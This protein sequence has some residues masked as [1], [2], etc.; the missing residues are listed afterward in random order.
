[1]N[2]AKLEQ[3]ETRTFAVNDA[4]ED[5]LRWLDANQCADGYWAGLLETNACIEAEWLL[6]MHFL[7]I[8]DAPKKEGIVRAIL[9]TQR[10]D[11]SWQ[12]Y[13]GAQDGDINATVESYAALRTCGLHADCEPQ[14]P[15]IGSLITVGWTRFVYLHDTGW[16]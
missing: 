1:M 4:I 11:G 8:R 12:I 3:N 13:Y 9:N 15:G 2:I 7:G 10:P 5:G 6:A 16:R 14:R